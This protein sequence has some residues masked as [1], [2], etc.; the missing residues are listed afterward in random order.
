MHEHV[1]HKHDMLQLHCVYIDKAS[2]NEVWQWICYF[3]L[4]N[5]HVQ[6]CL[7]FELMNLYN[8]VCVALNKVKL[9]AYYIRM[10][11]FL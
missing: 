9:Q 1:Q 5:I 8:T 10:T 2:K 6:S 11:Q 7:H 4:Q 3:R